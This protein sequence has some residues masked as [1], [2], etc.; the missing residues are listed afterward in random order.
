MYQEHPRYS[1]TKL[2]HNYFPVLVTV[3][4]LSEVSNLLTCWLLIDFF[5]YHSAKSLDTSM[6]EL[7]IMSLT[8]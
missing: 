1:G 3:T 5:S 2:L 4:L 8:S 7:I 6:F